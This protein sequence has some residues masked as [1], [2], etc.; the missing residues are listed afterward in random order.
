LQVL[1]LAGF[2]ELEKKLN[3]EFA[4]NNFGGIWCHIHHSVH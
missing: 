2:S 1:I 4:D 3:F